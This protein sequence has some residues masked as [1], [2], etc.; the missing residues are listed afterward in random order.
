MLTTP[1]VS[2]NVN[3]LKT[4]EKKQVNIIR[5]LEKL[6]AISFIQELHSD[7]KLK[8]KLDQ[9]YSG[10]AFYNHGTTNSRGVAIFF[11][12]TL[13]YEI[14]D[15]KRDT[16]GRIIII[17]T[18]ID[19]SEFIL[20]N[21]YA[22]TIQHRADQNNFILKL[23]LMLTEYENHNI[24]LGGDFNIHL[25]PKLD[26][27]DNC[28]SKNDNH[29]YRKELIS[30][31]ETYGLCDG[32]RITNPNSRRYTWHARGKASRLD[33]WFF[34]EHL[35]NEVTSYDILPGLHSDHSIVKINVGTQKIERSRGFW[36]FNSSILH[37][38]EYVNKIKEIIRDTENDHIELEDK[39]L[40]FE[41]IKM[42]VR[43]YTVPYCVTK[44]REKNRFKKEIAEKLEILQKEC[45]KSR[46]NE[47]IQTLHN[48]K[49][50]LEEIEK[51]E[52]NAIIFR[53]KARWIED[54]E[55]N[56]NYFM[57]LEKRNYENKLITT[58]NINGTITKDQ[59]DIS[60]AQHSY[61]KNLY[62]EK[63]NS[64]DQDYKSNLEKFLECDTI[65]KISQ[66]Q[67][68]DCEKDFTENEILCALK[69]LHNK[70]TPGSDG[71]PPEF[72]KFFWIDIKDSLL[73]SINYAMKNNE[74]SIEQKRGIITLIPKK[75][76]DRLFL[77]NWRPISLLNTDYKIIAKCLASRLKKV[78]PDIIDHDQTGYLKGRYIGQNIRLLEDLSFFADNK[79]LPGIILCIDFEKAFD[80]IN[81]NFMQGCLNKFGFGTNFI[82]YVKTMYTNIESCVLNNGSSGKYFKLER[83][84]RQGC[85]L[86]AYLFILTIETLAINIRTDKNIKGIKIDN[87]EIKISLLADDTTLLLEDNISL[88]F[89]LTKFKDFAKCSGL[90]INIEKT[91]AK[92]IGS[93]K[94][95]DY[96]PHGLSWIKTPL[97]TL[98]ITITNATNSYKHNFE[99]RIKTL[100]NTLKIWK[101]RKLS[102]KGKIT[103]LNNLALAPL[104]Y[105]SSVIDTPKKA[106]QEINDLIQNFI[107]N[108][109]TSKI[110]QKTLIQEI[111]NGGLK[112]CHFE[113]KVKSLKLSWVKRLTLNENANWTVLPKHFYKCSNLNIHFGANHKLVNKS[114]IP[115]FYLD[116]HTLFMKFFK[117]YPTTTAEILS[118]QLWQ[119]K[120]I[121]NKNKTLMNSKWIKN[122]I[123]KLKDIINTNGDFLTHTQL[124]DKY[125]TNINFLDLLHIHKCIPKQWILHLKQCNIQSTELTTKHNTIHCNNKSI[126]I[127][128]ITCKE[129]Y[130]HIINTETHQ[131]NSKKVWS[132]IFPKLEQIDENIWHRIFHNAF[133]NCKETRLQSFQYRIINNIIPC[134]KWLYDKK[135]KN[136][137]KCTLCNNENDNIVHFFLLCPDVNLFWNFFFKWWYNITDI[138]LNTIDNLQECLLLGF[139]GNH[140]K[141]KV[142]NHCIILAKYF[143][144][145]QKMVESYDYDLYKYQTLLK[146]RLQYEHN[147]S[148][149]NGDNDF[150]KYEFIYN[151]L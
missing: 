116:I 99:P 101:Q 75:N 60:N 85:P 94:D 40:K 126:N 78:L 42:K 86:S 14:L 29:N 22:P 89:A 19:Q 82:N 137:P 27:S 110:A 11:P 136:E 134:N 13:D 151:E 80:S 113:T 28:T 63:L 114:S 39:G 150:N 68:E 81:W 118:E 111:K 23:Q 48:L 70:K 49:K 32:W 144:F 130:W 16:D 65:P 58:L 106:I 46:N 18:R 92:Y 83:G 41:M 67:K 132:R 30:F 124:T 133:Q 7:D 38:T 88:G 127:K 12:N 6:K 87:R 146:K 51:Q 128:K 37:D 55:K 54:G 102:I 66:P 15:I 122:G 141:I 93:L 143:I 103:I 77:K 20:C 119:N 24:L 96:F 10:K 36:K 50:E 17:K 105:V 109:S 31:L 47:D 64:T 4:D 59:K 3:G 97:N 108:G 73:D 61:Y 100:S 76:K 72:Y 1:F 117:K 104:I 43:A 131:P 125:N 57:S 45:D 69:E 112:L 135:I 79:K 5:K 138:E 56:T 142:L 52:A 139:P 62:S 26:R 33:Y 115:Q 95:S 25:D 123:T 9:I 44:K 90:K 2:F 149:I 71:L 35:L 21:V 98:G 120:N 129:L 74:L 8:N 145:I 84:V 140:E 34:S 148:K 107:W 91:Q 121:T 53:S 147:T